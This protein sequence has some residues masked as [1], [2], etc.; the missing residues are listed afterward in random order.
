MIEW[1][2]F[3]D[4][5]GFTLLEGLMFGTKSVRVAAIMLAAT[6]LTLPATAALLGPS[7]L[8]SENFDSMGTAG[9]APPSGWQVLTITG[10]SNTWINATGS[11]STPAV[12]AIPNGAS[13]AGGTA[14][15]GLVVSEN[16]PVNQNNGFHATGASGATP[17]PGNPTAPTRVPGSPIPLQLTNGT[18]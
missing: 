3:Y 17:D 8:Y 7:G 9:T 6:C 16:P 4:V 11:N 14:S 18:P 13:L 5:I 2:R 15:A 12:G 1:L 10:A